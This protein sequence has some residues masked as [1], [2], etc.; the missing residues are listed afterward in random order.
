VPNVRSIRDDRSLKEVIFEIKEELR[1]FAITRLAMLREEL[2]EKAAHF[3]AAIPM[4]IAAI[5][6][7]WAAF[8][9]LTFGLVALIATAIDNPY[10]WA[11]GA[12][13]V[14]VV[15]AIIAAAVG[16]F[17]YH[18]ITTEGLAPNRTL[19]VLKQDQVWIQNEA[20]SA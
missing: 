14:F 15:Y 3:K 17:G 10:N 2:K 18:E 4:I 7:G 1:D 20:R 16:W 13:I 19:R 6:I 12:G 8:L 11:I 9:A 5:V